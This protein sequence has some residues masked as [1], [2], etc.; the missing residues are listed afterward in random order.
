MGKILFLFFILLS[1]VLVGWYISQ[2]STLQSQIDNIFH[3]RTTTNQSEASITPYPISDTSKNSNSSRLGAPMTNQGYTISFKDTG[4]EPQE[5]TIPV[6][7]TIRFINQSSTQ[8]QIMSDLHPDHLLLPEFVMKTA[9]GKGNVFD[10]TFT[11]I[12]TWR[13]HSEKDIG[14]T[15]T[16]IV[17]DSLM[18]K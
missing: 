4:F 15:G 11:T 18:T 8:M 9:V 16:I 13:Y 6:G 7:T 10:F 1:G 14:K 2:S 5:L 17:V 12:G 3:I